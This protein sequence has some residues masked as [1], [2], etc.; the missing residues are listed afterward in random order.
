MKYVDKEL[1][2]VDCKS[3]FI[4]NAGEQ[5]FFASKLLTP[6]KRCPG[7]RAAKKREFQERAA[8]AR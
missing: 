8:S 7:C 6:P 2:C 3:T 4:F 5:Q 1:T